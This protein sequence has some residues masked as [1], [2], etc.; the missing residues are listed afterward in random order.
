MLT[1]EKILRTLEGLPPSFSIDEF[2]DRLVL[3]NKIETGLEQSAA[4]QVMTT[5]QAREQLKKWQK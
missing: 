1:K 3:L 5:V 4:G 2:L